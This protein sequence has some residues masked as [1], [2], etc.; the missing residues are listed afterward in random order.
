MDQ[1]AFVDRFVKS[2]DVE[3]TAISKSTIFSAKVDISLLKQ[4]VY[5]PMLCAVKTK[6][7][8][9]SFAPSKTTLPPGAVT[10]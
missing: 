7:P 1:L 3:R 6:S 10:E 8:C 9:R 2:M 4:K 5:S